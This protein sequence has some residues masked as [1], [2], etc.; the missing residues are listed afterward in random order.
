MSATS[1]EPPN[2]AVFRVNRTIAEGITH[3]DDAFVVRGL[4]SSHCASS[5]IAAV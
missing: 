1:P 4:R 5:C 3:T 2:I